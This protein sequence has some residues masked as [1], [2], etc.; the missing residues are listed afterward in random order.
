[1]SVFTDLACE[2][3]ELN[4][5]IEGV[6]EQK[7]SFGDISVTRIRVTGQAAAEKLGKK[8]GSYVTIDAPALIDRPLELF[9]RTSERLAE[10][11]CGFMHGL[12]D[13]AEIMVVGLGNRTI[14]PDSLGPRTAEGVYVTR[15]VKRYVP[16]AFGF[17]VRSVA[18]VAPGVLGSTGVETLEAVKGLVERIRPD[19]I[20]AVDSLAS[21][22]ASRIST[23]IQLSD[24]GISPGSGVGNMRAGVNSETLGVPV[25]AVGVP[26]VVYASTITSDTISLIA[27]ETGL[28]GDE[29]KLK[30]LAE[31]VSEE[32]LDSMI[33]TPK[34][35]DSIVADMSGIISK[36]INLALFGERYEDVRMLIA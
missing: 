22:R 7:E 31:K 18:S 10:E 14:T 16:E 8:R 29:Q 15:H 12:G 26:L 21:R 33:V 9:D 1:M 20:I 25:I 23:T 5:D 17:P 3:R 24:A 4:P 32:K 34:D 2:A 27:D 30:M 11:L 19:I 35:I 28:H 13:N 6:E 36:A